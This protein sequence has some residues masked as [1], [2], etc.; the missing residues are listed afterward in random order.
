V[1]NRGEPARRCLRAIGEL[2]EEEGS[3]LVGIAL[4]TDPDQRSPYVREADEALS[5][6]PALRRAEG[7]DMRPAYLD[8]DRVM[9][10]L[11]AVRADAV[12]PGWGFLAEDP[13]FV[14][15]LEAAGLTFLGPSAE[16][17][18]ALGDKIMSKRLAESAEVPVT[19]WSGG[20]V[21][22]EE[23]HTV[24]E[25][26]GFPLMLKATAGGGGRGIRRISSIDEL[27]EAFRSASSEAANAFGDGTLF[28]EKCVDAA[29][30]V[31]VQLAADQRGRVLALGV[32]DCSVQRRHQKLIEE[33]P[34]PGTPR[35][36]LDE[37]QAAAVRLLERA[38]Y[39][40]VATVEFLLTDEPRFYFLEV[41]PR[42]QVEHGVTE[43]VT[44][45][46]LVKAQIRIARGERLPP[47]APPERG[48]AIEVR[49]CA[50]DPA[51]GFAPTPGRIALLDLPS[52][53]GV[54][55]DAGTGAGE[56]IPSEFDSML[57]KVIA[58][59]A[60]RDE[61]RA[62]LVRAV[63][64]LRLVVE[65]GMTN[66]GFLLDV[67]DHADFRRGG[68][69]TGWL[70]RTAIGTETDL[71]IDALLVAAI[72]TYQREREDVRLNFYVEASRGRPR[73]IPPSTG[74]EIDLV[75]G[76]V[77][78]RLKVFA[79]GGWSYRIHLGDR[80]VQV[81]LLEQGPHACQLEVGERRR[82]TACSATWVARCAHP[83]PPS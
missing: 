13:S 1:L 9:A 26:L 70:D 59:G 15:R 38:S 41:N 66:K 12:W 68:V 72:L 35:E 53:P 37:I 79:I 81:R 54:R 7:G 75:F 17:M 80:V 22:L 60:S 36:L 29:R 51:S 11:R 31:E 49:I 30:H 77:A 50:E 74:R 57:A 19:D 73:Q 46:D 18:R 33:E 34:P 42:L 21:N 69:D 62:R 39:I 24:A 3:D 4:F 10:A 83:H 63:S 32:R 52:G 82:S 71:D 67:L 78:Y 8:H 16:T 27:E 28:L 20:S 6:G 2:R 5:L 45:F 56:T 47:A 23:I 44:G 25:K 76:G 14:D 61:A 64:E 43:F 55:V 40:G 48:H 65:G 58:H